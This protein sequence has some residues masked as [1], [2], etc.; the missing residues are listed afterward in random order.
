VEGDEEYVCCSGAE[1]R[2]R[3][4]GCGK[5]SEGFAFPYGQCP[6]CGGKLEVAEATQ[7]ANAAALD[8]IRRAFE[9]ELGG[10][11]F[12][13]RAASEAQDPVLR[14]LF[15]RFVGMEREHMTTLSRRYH[16]EAPVPA[17]GIPVER[18]ALYAGVQSHP[19]DPAN[20]IALA[21]EFER[22]A[23]EYF[24]GRMS[25]TPEGSPERKLYQEL[26]AEEREHVA[27]LATEHARWKAGKPGL[28]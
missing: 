23:V 12:Y 4:Q 2:W 24:D 14:A 15:A 9:I 6:A 1:L 17:D 18:A 10:M 27:L 26:A 3:C 21:I 19:E 28:L 7:A 8:A 5:V 16:V 25:A 20:L 22:R 11:A 13:A